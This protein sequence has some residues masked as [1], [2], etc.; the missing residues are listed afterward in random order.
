MSNIRL[1]NA[2]FIFRPSFA[3]GFAAFML[4][5]SRKLT[6]LWHFVQSSS[7][8]VKCG[9]T[10]KPEYTTVFAP[11][12]VCM[13]VVEPGSTHADMHCLLP[14]RFAALRSEHL[15]HGALTLVVM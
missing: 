7:L 4:E 6:G 14:P 10:A 2:I 11:V 12:P 9:R 5:H 3:I 15:P 13:R 1:V 8:L